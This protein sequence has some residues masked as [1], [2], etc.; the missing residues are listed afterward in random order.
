M[1]CRKLRASPAQ[2]HGSGELMTS[3]DLL[4][5]GRP[6]E[7]VVG[8]TQQTTHLFRPSSNCPGRMTALC[9]TIFWSGDLEFLTA[10]GGMPCEHCLIVA[11]GMRP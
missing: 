8:C 4:I 1:G 11:P 7:G 6:F 2:W 5:L 3:T 10:I 9:G